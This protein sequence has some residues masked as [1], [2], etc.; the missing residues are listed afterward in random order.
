LF[1]VTLDTPQC[2]QNWNSFVQN[3]P[4]SINYKTFKTEF[5]YEEYLNILEIKYAI[6]LCRF[7]TTNNKLPIEAG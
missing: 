3:S 4:K 7:R 2:L 5:K 1:I 6:L